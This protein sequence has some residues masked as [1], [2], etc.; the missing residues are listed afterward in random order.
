MNTLSPAQLSSKLPKLN[1]ERI[2]IVGCGY[3]AEFHARAIRALK[4]AELVSV[5]DT[6]LHRARSFASRW[7]VEAVFDSLD[8]MLQAVRLDAI[9]VLVPPDLHFEMARQALQSGVHVLLEK[10]MCTS[11]TE[12][13]ELLQIARKK[14]LQ[15][16]V[17]H[18][19][20][21]TG[22]Y[23]QL[24]EA[25]GAGKLGPLDCISINYLFELEQI[26][27]GPFD[28]WMLRE[29]SNIFVE[30]AP[31]F[32][33]VV[34]DLLGEAT[35]LSVT[36]DRK[37]DLPDGNYV[38]RRWRMHGTAG[39]VAVNVN[40]YLGPGFGQRIIYVH[41]LFGS[42]TVD[43]DANTC[44]I[45]RTSIATD[46]DRYRRGSLLAWQHWLQASETLVDYVLS[47]FK[48]RRRGNP[49]QSSILGSVEAFYSALHSNKPLDRRIEGELGRDVV[50]WSTSIVRLA[51]IER[52]SSKPTMVGTPTVTPSV[53]VIGGSGFIGRELIRQLL[54]S[55]YGVRAMGRSLISRFD[56]PYSEN[57]ESIRGDVRSETDLKAA[58]RGM[59]FVYDLAVSSSKTW[60]E[61]VQDIVE[62]T[63]LLGEIC[64]DAGV[65]RLVYTGTIASYWTGA[66]AGIIT[67]ETPLDPKI[68][69]R[70]YYARAKAVAEEILMEMHRTNGLPVVIFRPGIVIGPG[71]NPFHWGVGKFSKNSCE[72]WGDGNN[73]LP[74]VLV[75]DVANAL[76]RG[77]QVPGIEGRSYNLVDDPLLTARDYMNELQRL[78]GV[79]MT[80]HYRP[81]W[82]FYV[83]DLV[84]WLVKLVV[85][86]PD[87]VRIPSY[88]DWESRTNNAIFDCTGARTELKWKPASESR[89]LIDEGIAGS[90]HSWLHAWR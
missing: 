76:V 6:N 35:E 65:K 23:E 15:V 85:G 5:C 89:R 45:D 36:V 52:S 13:D 68:S 84:K 82:R 79:I 1:A 53:L 59:E 34:L 24:R 26:R 54:A 38:V 43:L 73:K 40:M 14:N 51:N 27:L 72:V 63:R 47:L 17:N 31:H 75:T 22:A 86:H 57:L 56:A 71:G 77:I 20:L 39:R 29:P 21:F 74:F 33:S 3:I 80:V 88:H 19:F 55:G 11:T 69:R 9:H 16:G 78:A 10:P 2:A 64:L 50:A 25:I 28:S 37:V 32:L 49:Y 83:S 46:F 62:P 7:N 90:L 30:T 41:G 48:L 4:N 66:K 60:T 44:V 8:S 18:N 70:N 58:M 12:A 42:A 81:L 61:S 87:R 67:D